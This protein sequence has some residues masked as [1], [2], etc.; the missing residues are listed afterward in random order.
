MSRITKV[1]PLL[2]GALLLSAAGVQAQ[3][4]PAPNGSTAAAAPNATHKVQPDATHKVQPDATHKV[5]ASSTPA[6]SGTT[7]SNPSE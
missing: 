6:P 3:N 2:C 7:D 1:I 5:P 4:T